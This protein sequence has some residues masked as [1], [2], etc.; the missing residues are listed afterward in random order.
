MGALQPNRLRQKDKRRQKFSVNQSARL[1]L[2]CKIVKLGAVQCTST[3]TGYTVNI[4]T[5]ASHT[6]VTTQIYFITN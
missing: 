4:V 3:V 5:L 6:Y 1:W 2:L